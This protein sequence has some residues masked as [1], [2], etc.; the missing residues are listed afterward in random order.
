MRAQKE[1]LIRNKVFVCVGSDSVDRLLARLNWEGSESR[2]QSYVSPI[3][4]IFILKTTFPLAFGAEQNM[5][6]LF[7]RN[8]WQS[9]GNLNS[10]LFRIQKLC[11]YSRLKTSLSFGLKNSSQ[12][13]VQILSS[14]LIFIEQKLIKISKALPKPLRS[15]SDTSE[16]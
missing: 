7:S 12:T 13:N 11:S 14:K 6:S 4:D 10:N 2:C 9:I 15:R 1:I 5:K 16:R 8:N 3:S